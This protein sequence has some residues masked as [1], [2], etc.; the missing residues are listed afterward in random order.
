M[1]ALQKLIQEASEIIEKNPYTWG[2]HL[3]DYLEEKESHLAIRWVFDFFIKSYLAPDE[4][5]LKI[6]DFTIIISDLENSI[7]DKKVLPTNPKE[8][9]RVYFFKNYLSVYKT[10]KLFYHLE[11][12]YYAEIRYRMNDIRNYK[13]ALNFSNITKLSYDYEH[14]V[15]LNYLTEDCFKALEHFENYNR[16]EK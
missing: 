7:L 13:K 10:S 14:K 15:Y 16:G 5:L 6:L 9:K 8:A 4:N 12:L 1:E 2:Y 3:I 11:S